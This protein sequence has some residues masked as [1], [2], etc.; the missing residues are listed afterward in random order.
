MTFRT[1][2]ALILGALVLIPLVAAALLV[3]YAVPRAT[4][5]RADSLVVSTRSSV[6]AALTTECQ[7]SQVAARSVGRD[8]AFLSPRAA[9]RNAVD[10]GL[11]DWA[12]LLSQ[13]GRV[14]GEAGTLPDGA[15]SGGDAD[16]EEGTADGPNVVA[17]VDIRVTG[18]P[19]LA[20]ARAAN[21]V[22]IEYLDRLNSSIGFTGDIALLNGSEVVVSSSDPAIHATEMLKALDATTG[23][24]SVVNQGG[25]TVSVAKAVPGMP[26]DVVVAVPK[27]RQRIPD[28]DGVPRRTRCGRAGDLRRGDRRA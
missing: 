6:T 21:V 8:T 26:F 16:C 4:Q 11:A 7:R 2:L 17:N 25:F 10:D 22:D 27:P 18:K 3:V 28:S 14:L 1:R 23:D 9:A 5:D 13:S 12:A 20:E 19:D 15:P 24:A